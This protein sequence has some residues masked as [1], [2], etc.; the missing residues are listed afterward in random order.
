LCEQLNLMVDGSIETIND[1][2]FD[3]ADA[4]LIEE[5][6]DSFYIDLEL[7]SEPDTRHFAE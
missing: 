2:F 4:P 7:I 5:D 6:S 1:R 3:I